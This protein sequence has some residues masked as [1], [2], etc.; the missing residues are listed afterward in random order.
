M[1]TCDGVD[2]ADGTGV[3][4]L[5]FEIGEDLFGG[6]VGI[7]GV[8]DDGVTDVRKVYTDLMGAPGLKL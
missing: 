4:A 6:A 2:K 7:N 8:A 3:E 1:L 5:A